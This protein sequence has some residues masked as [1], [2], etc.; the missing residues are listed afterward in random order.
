MSRKQTPFT[1]A[2]IRRAVR[3]A[4]SSGLRVRR[5]TINPD[6]SIAIDAGENAP[7]VVDSRE[8]SLAASWDDV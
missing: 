1:Q 3:A 4:E 2:Q 8:S 5:I 6:G 7:I